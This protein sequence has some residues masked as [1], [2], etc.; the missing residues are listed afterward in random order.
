[1]R[2]Q[3][4]RKILEGRGIKGVYVEKQEKAHQEGIQRNERKN[5]RQAE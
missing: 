2:R 4:E 5:G 1:M 3:G